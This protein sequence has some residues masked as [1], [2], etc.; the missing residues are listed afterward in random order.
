MKYFKGLTTGADSNAS[1]VVALLEM[2][3]IFSKLYNDEATKGKYPL[4]HC[5]DYIHAGINLKQLIVSIS[6]GIKYSCGVLSIMQL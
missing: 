2:A 1:G 4:I 3:R 6:T 5:G